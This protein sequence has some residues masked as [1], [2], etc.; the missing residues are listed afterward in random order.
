MQFVKLTLATAL[1]GTLCLVA[2]KQDKPATLTTTPTETPAAPAAAKPETWLYWV[3]VDNLLLRDQPTKNGS[4]VVTKFPEGDFVV[5]TGEKSANKEEATLRNIPYNEPYYRVTSTTPEQ[6]NGWAYGGALV[7]V[8]AGTTANSPDLGRLSQFSMFLKTLN[9]KKLESGK[10]AWDYVSTNLADARGPLADAAFVM[11]ESFLRRMEFEGELYAYTEKMEWSEAD[12]K[13]VSDNTFDMNRFPATKSLAANGFT[14]D[15]GEGMVFPVTDFQRLADFFQ[16][17]TTGPMQQYLTQW[18][19]EQKDRDSDDGGLVIALEQIVDRA[20]F[21]ERFNQANP[22][23]VLGQFTQLSA[24]W[25][26]LTLTNGM[27]NT[28]IC[29]YET[30]SPTEDAKKAWAYAQQ[31]YPGTTV[32]QICKKISELS[33]ADGGKCGPQVKAFQE[34]TAQLYNGAN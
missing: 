5:G 12:Y 1:L 10:K 23:F 32:A 29:D 28:P 6:H 2:C 11:L 3:T 9:T 26:L 25:N 16:A 17:K 15:E 27:D 8:Y 22:Y 33:A 21:W 7:A 19:A 20:V 31:K 4:K 18:A 24:G 14:L 30:Q 13:A 34:Q